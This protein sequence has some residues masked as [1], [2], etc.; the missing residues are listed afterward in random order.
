MLADV[1]QVRQQRPR[2]VGV[3]VDFGDDAVLQLHLDAAA[4]VALQA[5]RVDLVLRE[6]GGVFGIGAMVVEN[7]VLRGVLRGGRAGGQEPQK[8]AAAEETPAR[9]DRVDGKCG[10]HGERG[11]GFQEG[12]LELLYSGSRN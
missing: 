6:A 11:E 2:V 4:G 5:D 3:A 7:G 10:V 12:L 8:R 1:R 9:T